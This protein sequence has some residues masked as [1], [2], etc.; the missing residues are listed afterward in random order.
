M[1]NIHN[2][3]N[4]NRLKYLKVG[5]AFK[6]ALPSL[7]DGL[8]H[9]IVGNSFPFLIPD[10]PKSLQLLHVPT[11]SNDLKLPPFLTHFTCS[12]NIYSDL[13][14][15]L[16][17]LKA[18]FVSKLNL[19]SLIRLVVQY[20]GSST[21]PPSLHYLEANQIQGPLLSITL[22]PLLTHLILGP[23]FTGSLSSFPSTLQHLVLP[24]K[25]SHALHLPPHLNHFTSCSNIDISQ[26]PLS[27]SRLYLE[28]SFNKPIEVY[29]PN[30]LEIHFGDSFDWSVDN[31]PDKVTTIVFGERFNHPIHSLPSKLINLTFGMCFNNT[32][33]N[34]PSNLQSLVFGHNF[35]QQI[36]SLPSSL[37]TLAF[38]STYN[39]PT[40]FNLP[41][42]TRLTFKK[43][44]NH[45]LAFYPSLEQ[46]TLGSD[47][48]LPLI[49]L[50]PSITH[51]TFGYHFNQP[52]DNLPPRLTHLT[53]GY[54]FNQPIDRLPP[55]LTHLILG[56]SFNHPIP[57]LPPLT[58][59]KLSHDFKFPLILSKLPP[60]LISL[61]IPW[62]IP[63][64]IED[65]GVGKRQ[66]LEE[67]KHYERELE[68]FFNNLRHLWLLGGPSTQP[69][70]IFH[71]NDFD[72]SSLAP[73]Y[74]LV[75]RAYVNHRKRLKE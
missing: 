48:N 14:P 34:L 28:S 21:L 38:G 67:L 46:L 68:Q 58:L 75:F 73:P 4:I 22:P 74:C 33:H 8:T 26:L 6:Q 27:L 17:Y 19:P 7:P 37:T 31:L 59:L 43:C 52:L 54:K 23:H 63:N 60:S 24:L 2:I 11:Y 16:T 64:F 39:Q 49:N 20:L 72:S 47:F 71:Y 44:Y 9:L 29:P 62:G 57:D 15:S 13:P 1:F 42:L 18:H 3:I 50:S 25:Y 35:N 32:I 55:F 56:S 10:L 30:L 65:D 45:P 5:K 61:T 12:N 66:H 51:L 69:T 36:K 70:D 41:K 53:L 40:N